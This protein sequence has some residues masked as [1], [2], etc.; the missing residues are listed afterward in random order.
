MIQWLTRLRA[1]FGASFIWLVCLIYFTQ[2]FRSFVWTAVSYQLKDRLKLSP[3]SS[4]FAFSIAFFP[5]S[6]KPLYG[7]VSDCIPI[8]GRKRVPYLVIATVLSLVPWLILGLNAT[9]RNSSWQLMTFLTVQNLGSAMA[10]VVVDAMIAEAVRHEK[11]SFAGDL[12]SISWFAMAFGGICGSLLGG[13]ALTNLQIHTIF[14]LF[15]VLPS[16]QLLSCGLV[17]EKSV[18]SKVLLESSDWRSSDGANGNSSF[19][20]DDNF[21][22]K[23]NTTMSRRKKSNKGKQKKSVSGKLEFA[24]KEDSLA[25]RWFHSLKA[26]TYSL[27]HAFKQPL[28]LRPMAWFFLA[29]VS[30]PNLSTV[31]FYYQTESLSLDASF[32][33]TARVVGWLGLMLGTFVYNRYLKTMKLRRILM[34]SH[35]GL[36]I[37]TLLDLVL[38]TRVNLSYGISDKIMVLFG[39]ALSDAIN[40]FKFMP[41]LILS[42]QLC[43]PGIEGTLFALFMSINNL[44]ST[45][46]SFVGAGVASVLNI[47]SGSFDNLPLGIAIQILCTFIPIGFLFLIPK[48]ATGLSARTTMRR[49]PG[50]GGLQ[51]A[52]ASRDQYRLLGENVAKIRTDLMKEQLTTF[53]TQLEDFARKHKNDIRKNPAFRSQFHNMCTKVGVDPLA[54]NKGFWAELLGIGDFY[55]ELGVQIVDICLATRPHNGGL[56]NLQELCSLLRQRRKSDREAVSEDDCLRAI[57]KLKVLGNG[58]EVI[59]VGKRKLVR[60][61]PT[62]LNKDHN[63]ILELAQAQG[64]VTVPEV[65]RRL[66]WTTGRAIDAFDTLLDEGL[67]MIDD[68][69][70]DGVRRYWFPCVSSISTPLGAD[71]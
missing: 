6:V 58:Y 18:G 4:Q 51:N 59:S 46:G 52:A 11:A 69:H 32:L 29:H 41:F 17:E 53:R 48:E 14:L 2:G 31:M 12:Q 25:S 27:C 13:Y 55:Y 68:G 23:S 67:A 19:L 50:I 63:E 24:G 35:L 65:E 26:A 70:K 60:S 10:D 3:S 36:S 71:S 61:V 34:L 37:L 8:K 45:L 62:E 33:G 1:A 40:Q 9:L 54:S 43:P 20:D 66:S 28:I 49:R 15:S 56:I 30:I 39:S 21:S 5:W 16:I 22:E 38:V 42:G 7:I 57:S 47:S 44:G 64:F